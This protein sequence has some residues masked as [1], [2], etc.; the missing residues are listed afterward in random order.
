M[1]EHTVEKDMP[2]WKT[3]RRK[4]A[5][6]YFEAVEA[7]GRRTVGYEVFDATHPDHVHEWEVEYLPDPMS[8][9]SVI[10][11]GDLRCICGETTRDTSPGESA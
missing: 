2:H 10:R 8:A 11:S 6:G 7:I 1:N 9:G 3:R 5:A 4:M